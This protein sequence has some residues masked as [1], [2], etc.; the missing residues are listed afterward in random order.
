MFV[1]YDTLVVDVRETPSHDTLI[2]YD[3][4][5]TKNYGL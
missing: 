5:K 4:T 3:K 1:P 2:V